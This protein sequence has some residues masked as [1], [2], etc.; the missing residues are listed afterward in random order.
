MAGDGGIRDGTV[1]VRIARGPLYCCELGSCRSQHERRS[2]TS[3]DRQYRLADRGRR[4]RHPH[5]F[6]PSR[7]TPAKTSPSPTSATAVTTMPR[8]RS[9]TGSCATGARTSRR[10]W[11][12]ICSTCCGR[13]TARSA[14]SEPIQVI[15]GYRSPDTNSM[16]RARSS[17]VAQFSLHT[18][19]D[20]MDFYIPGVPLEDDPRSRPADA[21]RRRRL[22]SDLRLA[23][24]PSRYRLGAALAA[25]D[26]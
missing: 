8:C 12:R 19:G 23:V 25:H 6:L 13:P 11:T 14:A 22:L 20:A 1:P 10:R 4:R 17:G 15:C 7:S 21:A 5:H 2:G 26:A 16:L 3:P 24:H 18:Q 9:S